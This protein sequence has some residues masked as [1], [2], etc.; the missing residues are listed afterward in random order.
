MKEVGRNNV[1]FWDGSY[2]NIV[3]LDCG[4]C[5]AEKPGFN[6]SIV[7]C[8]EHCKDP[9]GRFCAHGHGVRER[10]KEKEGQEFIRLNSIP[11]TMVVFPRIWKNK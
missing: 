7:S 3:D 2:C 1:S 6:Q 9:L 5:Y 4:C 11:S 8:E 10:D